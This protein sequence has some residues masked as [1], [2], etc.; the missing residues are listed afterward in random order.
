MLFLTIPRFYLYFLLLPFMYLL[1]PYYKMKDKRTGCYKILKKIKYLLKGYKAMKVDANL[2]ILVCCHKKTNLPN[3]DQDILLPIQVGA[4]KSDID[5]GFQKD[6]MIF[7]KTCDNISEKNN[8]YC[9]LTAMYWAWKNIQAVYPG[10][11]Y[12]GLCH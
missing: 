8:I 2:K 12:I 9:E 11:N 5:L 10:I 4:S 1:R 6:N 7:E 3:D